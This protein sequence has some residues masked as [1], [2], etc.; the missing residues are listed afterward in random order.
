MRVIGL[1]P[2]H[3]YVTRAKA[4]AEALRQCTTADIQIKEADPVQNPDALPR[5][6]ETI[7][8]PRTLHELLLLHHGNRRYLG[9]LAR[10]FRRV[11]RCGDRLLIIDPNYR[12]EVHADTRQYRKRIVAAIARIGKAYGHFHPTTELPTPLQLAVI[13][14]RAGY[15]L[16]ETSW[17]ENEST[18]LSPIVGAHF[19]VFEAR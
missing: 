18:R 16:I 19:T 5:R 12:P 9:R 1:E 4:V 14:E 13:F 2:D 6:A 15:A 10:I 8:L 17:R 3:H 7:I 11:Q